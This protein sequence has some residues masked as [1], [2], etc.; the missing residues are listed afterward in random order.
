MVKI[1]AD[2]VISVK[3]VLNRQYGCPKRQGYAS[4]IVYNSGG[5]P[6]RNR[7]RKITNFLYTLSTYKSP[8]EV[9]VNTEV[10]TPLEFCGEVFCVR[11]L[12]VWINGATEKEYIIRAISHNCNCR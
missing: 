2:D 3:N 11:Q 1:D 9:N 5:K 4:S 10:R 6:T 12:A 8:M 7:K